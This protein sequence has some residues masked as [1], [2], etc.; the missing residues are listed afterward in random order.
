MK[1]LAVFGLCALVVLPVLAQ[2]ASPG[3]ESVGDPYFRGAG[4]GGYDVQHYTLEL[5]AQ[6]DP[7]EISGTVTIDALATQA[8]SAFN[9]DFVGFEI[10]EL[11]LNG[12]PVDYTREGRELTIT[13]AEPLAEG[14]EIQVA[15]TYSGEPGAVDEDID[16]VYSMGWINYDDGVFVASEPIGAARWFPANDH[17]TDKA[18]YTFRITVPDGL[19]VAANGL[20]QETIEGENGEI[21]YVFEHIHPM[22]SYLASI[23]IAD[24]VVQTSETKEGLPLRNYCPA[25][26]AES[27]EETFV[28]QG[29]MLTYFSTL[30][31][32]YPF[33]TYGA[34]VADTQLGFA[35]ENQTLSLF[36]LDI[37]EGNATRD[38]LTIAHEL[39]HQ[40]YG[41]SITPARWQDIW[42]NEGFATYA[43]ALWL[44]HVLGTE[45]R[46]RYLNSLYTDISNITL[47]NSRLGVPALPPPNDLFNP[48]V[49]LRGGLTLHA[50]RV[51]VGDEAFFNILRTYSERYRYSVATTEDFTA[52]AEEISGH[53]LDGFFTAWLFQPRMPPLP[54]IAIENIGTDEPAA[55]EDV[56]TEEPV[57]TETLAP[58]EEATAEATAVP[59]EEP[60]SE[61]T[62]E[63]T[64]TT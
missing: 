50:L 34:V 18:T 22:A 51:E 47:N 3:A 25:D 61:T 20:L 31:G 40:W 28:D 58:T 16:E 4:N 54:E 36:G 41:D 56:S 39:A 42:L 59:T 43:E 27:C 8:L 19:V 60:T 21:T 26:R 37:L 29:E 53:E 33:E 62:P 11:T 23:N 46:D 55:T 2:D 6:L 5:S 30:F 45:F 7:N 10:S 24:F 64:A 52:L 32:P 49:Y 35:L 17:P 1:A 13:P 12:E 14:A 63:S 44:E 15:V 9:L 48:V 38:Q 57:A